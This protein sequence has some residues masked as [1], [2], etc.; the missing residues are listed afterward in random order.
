MDLHDLLKLSG[1]ALALLLYAPLIVGA[2]RENGAGQSYA[3]WAL[4]AMLNT[5]ITER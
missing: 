3:M 5:L 4:W 2:I 1:G